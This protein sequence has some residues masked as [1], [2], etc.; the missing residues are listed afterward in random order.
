MACV[1]AE[2]G[3]TARTASRSSQWCATRP[4][5]LDNL[6][7]EQIVKSVMYKTQVEVMDELVEMEIV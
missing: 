4:P 1:L 2:K 7:F 6:H 5:F 3:S